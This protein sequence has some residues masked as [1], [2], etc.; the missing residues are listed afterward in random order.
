MGFLRK[1]EV[2]RIWLDTDT[3]NGDG[4]D[5]PPQWWVDVKLGLSV[6]EA[7]KAEEALINTRVEEQRTAR[8]KMRTVV[9]PEMRLMPH[10]FEVV[11]CSI[12]NWNLTD[13][14][15]QPL[16]LDHDYEV[17]EKTKRPSP[18]RLSLKKIPQAS[19]DKISEVVM[20][21]NRPMSRE[22][23]ASFLD[24]GDVDG[25][26]DRDQRPDDPGVPD[27]AD[28]VEQDGDE[29]RPQTAVGAFPSGG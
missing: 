29:D 26:G 15:D 7:E 23:T 21:A 24:A 19:Y 4:D 3:D 13:E 9:R 5:S 10:M 16:P 28:V 6:E 12:V 17:E 1:A 14:Q 2:E 25:P 11:L 22:E 20:A 27:G 8:G 18:R